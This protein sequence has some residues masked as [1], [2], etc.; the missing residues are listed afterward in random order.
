MIITAL[1]AEWKKAAAESDRASDEWEKNPESQELQEAFD[2]AY[3]KDFEL[4]E[5][6][7]KEL[8]KL[9]IARPVANKMIASP[10][11]EAIVRK[12]VRV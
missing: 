10:E 2:K 3:K 9:G 11:F 5:A 6:L 4:H 8:K 1:Y 12:A 7:V